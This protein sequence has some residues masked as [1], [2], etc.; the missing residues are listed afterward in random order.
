MRFYFIRHAATQAN[1]TGIMVKGYENS[2]IDIL[3]KPD[4]WE[5]KVG[6]HIPDEARQFIISSPAKRCVS[7]AKLLFDRYPDEVTDVLGEFDCKNLGTNKFWEITEAEFNKLVH[8]PATTMAKRAM[9][10][11]TDMGN[12]ILT[13]HNTDSVVAISHGMIIRYLYHFMSGNPSISAYDIINSKGFQFS[14]LDLLVV[15][16]ESNQPPVAYHY[17]KPIERA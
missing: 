6:I 3:D 7:T 10:I 9:D 17:S 12:L 2:D 8:L 15:D 1:K 16:T 4:D 11:L 14:N 13:E 5:E